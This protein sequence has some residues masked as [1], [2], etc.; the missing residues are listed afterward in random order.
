MPKQITSVLVRNPK[1]VCAMVVW[2]ILIFFI[3]SFISIIG[4][5]LF[6]IAKDSEIRLDLAKHKDTVKYASNGFP[7]K[8]KSF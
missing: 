2:I 6:T 7:T 8:S 3:G 5:T 1:S 4:M